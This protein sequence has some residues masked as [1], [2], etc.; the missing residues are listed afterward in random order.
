MVN[1]EKLNNVVTIKIEGSFKFNYFKI[2]KDGYS[3]YIDNKDLTF[4]LDFSK[5]EFVD[6]SAL[7]MLLIFREEVMKDNSRK[8]AIKIIRAI[9]EV[10]NILNIANFGKLFEVL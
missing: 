5:V 10:S 9:P 8:S 2:F 6:S 3:P 4:V 7:G 1:V